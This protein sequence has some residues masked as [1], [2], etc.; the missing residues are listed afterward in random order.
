MRQNGEGLRATL[1]TRFPYALLEKTA[2]IFTFGL[3]CDQTTQFLLM[4]KFRCEK[5]IF[6]YGKWQTF[7]PFRMMG[8][9]RVTSNGNR[10]DESL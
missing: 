3:D 8:E 10:N 6:F 5:A 9:Q 1:Y 7:M 2:H 4:R